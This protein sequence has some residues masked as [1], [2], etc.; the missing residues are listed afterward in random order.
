METKINK[1]KLNDKLNDFLSDENIECT[2][3]QCILKGDKSLVERISK[4]LI[5]DDGRQLLV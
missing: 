1:K 5:T 4:K 3:E 2:G